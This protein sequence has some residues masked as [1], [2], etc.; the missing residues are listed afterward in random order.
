MSQT[1]DDTVFSL[2]LRFAG[3]NQE[4]SFH[5]EE[6]FK[7]QL[8]EIKVHVDQYPLEER[9]E[10]TLKWIEQHATRYRN[11]WNK[12]IISQEV[13]THRCKDCPLCDND[14]HGQCEIHDQWVGL[15]QKY[16]ASEINSRK[17]IEELLTLLVS[18]KEDLKIKLS[19]LSMK[20]P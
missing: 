17:Y 1:I 16:V 4:L 2:I 19:H 13:S 15:L 5:D 14:S 8:Q 3:Y 20:T 9:G 11:T 10:H 6:F 12:K 7:K 18:H